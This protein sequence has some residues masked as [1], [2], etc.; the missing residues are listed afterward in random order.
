MRSIALFPCSYTDGAGII[1]ELSAALRLQV[2]TDDML[3]ADISKR[4]GVPVHELKKTIFAR[5]SEPD[6]QP[7]DKEKYITFARLLLVAP[8]MLYSGRRMF[9][10]LHTA[11]LDTAGERIL[12]VL[13]FDSEERRMRRAMRQEGC[14]E[15]AAREYIRRHDE[16]VSRWTRYLCGKDAYDRSLYDFFVSYDNNGLLDITAQIVQQY[17]AAYNPSKPFP[18]VPEYRI[19][20]NGSVAGLLG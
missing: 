17:K 3:F 20:V 2:Y 19:P 5:E 10:G 16:K 13:V 12:K 9:Y 7:S 14:K 4:F 6:R 18:V 11:L 15:A 1:G 8:T